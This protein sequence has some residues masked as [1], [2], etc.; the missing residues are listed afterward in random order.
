[1]GMY[2]NNLLN[3]MRPVGGPDPRIPGWN[4]NQMPQPPIVQPP[5]Q[6][7]PPQP[8]GPAPPVW[9]GN[10]PFR[11]PGPQPIGPEP[12]IWGGQPPMRPPMMPPTPMP[13]VQGGPGM[14]PEPGANGQPNYNALLARLQMSRPGMMSTM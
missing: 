9:G 2:N 13:P 6:V 10:P 5:I 8:V 7:G 12:P 14:W 11:G 3:R 4:G 1:M